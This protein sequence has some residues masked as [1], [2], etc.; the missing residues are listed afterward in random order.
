MSEV[1]VH[2]IS[3]RNYLR[4][5]IILLI[6]SSFFISIY[7]GSV[8]EEKACVAK[9]L[10]VF[11]LCSILGAFIVSI[12]VFV[13]AKGKSL[14]DAAFLDGHGQMIAPAIHIVYYVFKALNVLLMSL[15]SFIKA[16]MKRKFLELLQLLERR[17][18]LYECRISLVVLEVLV[19][20]FGERSNDRD[21]WED[22]KKKIQEIRH[23]VENLQKDVEDR[24]LKL[25]AILIA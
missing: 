13:H 3:D 5:F 1:F 8:E 23:H 4:A 18:K 9:F 25:H 14:D 17:S 24:I 2:S 7:S 12:K 20:L 6:L 22:L 11:L 16:L 15:A 10:L 21:G 19:E